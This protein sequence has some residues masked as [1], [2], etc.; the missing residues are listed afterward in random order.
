MSESP[1]NTTEPPGSTEPPASERARVLATDR[2]RLALDI[3]EGQ[4]TPVELEELAAGIV[5]REDG[6]T[7][8]C[9]ETIE[10]VAISLHHSHLPKLD[11]AGVLDYDPESHRI[12]PDGVPNSTRR[13]S[14]RL[15]ADEL[16]ALADRQRR[17]VLLSLAQHERATLEELSA[18]IAGEDT[19]TMDT[20][21]TRLH[22]VHLPRLEDAGFV[23]YDT[24]E[25]I[26]E[27]GER[28]TGDITELFDGVKSG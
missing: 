7:A 18:E 5:A 26:V 4:T 25:H 27:A 11:D 1:N 12:D 2:R 24:D 22:H 14:T 13:G 6:N 19:R 8:V 10:Q 21:T 23:R 20:S 3:L 15:S 28:L 16:D 9:E 17:L